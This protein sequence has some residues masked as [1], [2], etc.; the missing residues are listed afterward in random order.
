MSSTQSSAPSSTFTQLVRQ[1]RTALLALIAA[2]LVLGLAYPLAVFAVGRL[3]PARADGQVVSADGREVGSAV[4]GQA[5][6]GEQWFVPRPSAAGDGYDPL[7]SGASN[8]GPESRDLLAAVEERRAAAAAAD[9]TAPADVAPD[10]LTA[11]GS[12]LDPHVSPEYAQQ[13]VAR[14]AAARGLG[15]QQV[16]DLVAEHVQGRSLGFLGE[17]RVNV[18][19]LNL[20]LQ[21]LQP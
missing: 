1:S 9:G 12:G 3:V 16:A 17:P 2:T 4:V 20:A 11:S 13:Q 8:L 6:E 19:E 15:E 14:V 18:L 21:A 5:F 10:A 7:A